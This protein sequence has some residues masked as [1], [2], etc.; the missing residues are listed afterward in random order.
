MGK[1]KIRNE[2]RATLLGSRIEYIE[3]K[4]NAEQNK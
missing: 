2:A 4:I 3:N 1:V